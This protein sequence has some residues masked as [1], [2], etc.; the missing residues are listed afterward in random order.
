MK[1][2]PTT[3]KIMCAIFMLVVSLLMGCSISQK[4]KVADLPKTRTI[5]ILAVNDMHAAIDNFPRF[6]FMIDSLRDI[7]PNLLL[8]SGGDNQTGN[9]AND[10]Y[11]EKGMPII[12]LMNA[13]N[14][15]LSAVGN[16]EFDSRLAGF[17]YIT[18]QAKFDFLNANMII[19]E[20]ANFRIIPYK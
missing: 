17:E 2:I 8:V 13:V 3:P 20:D 10:Q 9:P 14:F 1:T 4:I 11:S 12:E 6:A 7:Y 15:D 16:H 18:Q 5:E 19:P